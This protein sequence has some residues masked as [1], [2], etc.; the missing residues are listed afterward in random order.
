MSTPSCECKRGQT[1]EKDSCYK[2]SRAVR[3]VRGFGSAPDRINGAGATFPAPI[4][5]KWFGEYK[6]AHPGVQI[7]YQPIGSGGGIKQLTEGTVDFGAS[8]MP[9]TDEQIAEMKVKPLH[10]PTVLGAVVLTYNIPG[11]TSQPELHAVR[12]SPASTS[13]ASPS[14][15]IR[16]SRLRTPA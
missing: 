4:Y 2:R 1:Y 8:D 12:R 3:H 11:V 16:K 5:Q 10:F 15:T 13:A 7:N 14:G 9:M 6:T